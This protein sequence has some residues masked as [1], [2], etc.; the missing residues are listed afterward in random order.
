MEFS[1]KNNELLMH[2]SPMRRVNAL[3]DDDDDD[4]DRYICDDEL[5]LEGTLTART[6]ATPPIILEL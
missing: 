5:Y 3:H 4:D 6:P 2:L 1:R